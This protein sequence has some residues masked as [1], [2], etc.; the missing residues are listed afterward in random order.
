MTSQ[1]NEIA[2]GNGAETEPPPPLRL[3]KSL[4]LNAGPSTEKRGGL[5]TIRASD[6]VVERVEWIWPG[7]IPRG[8]VSLL[9]GPPGKGKTTL[10]CEVA[11]R[12]S[13]GQ[14]GG[15]P[16]DVLI[17]SA[18]DS[19]AF[20]LVPRLT[21]AGADL[22]R[23][24]FVS[25][26]V[27]DDGLVLPEDINRL[28]VTVNELG[29]TL[30]IIDPVVAHLGGRIDSHND[31]SVRTALRPLHVLAETTGAAVLGIVHLNKS[32]GQDALTRVGGSVGF[33]AAARS[34]LL[35]TDDPAEE[36]G[37][38]RRLLAHAKSNVGA[39][40]PTRRYELRS[41]T[42][43]DPKGGDPIVTS[44]LGSLGDD[45][46]KANDLLAGADPDRT[47]RDSAKDIIA[48]ALS[49]G[50]KS[51]DELLRLLR[52]DGISDRTGRRARDEMRRDGLIDKD[53]T[54]RGWFWHL[55]EA[56]DEADVEF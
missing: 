5:S 49:D 50:A 35:L 52:A 7:R 43:E 38:S 28:T 6:V 33:T 13:R 31:K 9:A 47:E 30:V 4:T 44:V 18:E 24:H 10:A 34:V 36:E 8:L 16:G 48:D 51:W 11:A 23:V 25:T 27:E 45:P 22:E 32:S 39:L 1:Q 21:A 12:V 20:T 53:K 42:I 29:V 26:E 56:I 54:V 55:A 14:L 41:A 19:P 17:A 2:L 37:S 15:E 3:V 40:A 46:R